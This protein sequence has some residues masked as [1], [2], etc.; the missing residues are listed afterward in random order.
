[1]KDCLTVKILTVDRQIPVMEC[2]TVLL[3]VAD[4]TNG[5][6]SGCYGIK[7]GHARTVFSLKD[8]E[9]VLSDSGKSVLEAHISGGFA[10]VDQNEV[11]IMVDKI[12]EK[13]I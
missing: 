2:D 3:P 13:V 7:K 9:L 12:E 8:G 5:E 6:F 10:I 1:M 4:S 11:S